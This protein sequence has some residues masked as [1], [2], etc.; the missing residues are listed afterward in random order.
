VITLRGSAMYRE[1]RTRVTMNSAKFELRTSLSKINWHSCELPARATAER[2]KEFSVGV[3]I[4][5]HIMV[6]ASLASERSLSDG[7]AVG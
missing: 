7:C 2:G 3:E 5:F 6:G 1:S 4:A